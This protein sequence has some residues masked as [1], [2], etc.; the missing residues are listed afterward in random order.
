MAEAKAKGPGIFSRMRRYFKDVVG[1]MKKVVWPSRKQA[2]NNTIVVLIFSVA[3]SLVIF[4]FDTLLGFLVRLLFGIG[5][6]G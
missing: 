3:M 4:G 6:G 1:E 2:I 5:Y